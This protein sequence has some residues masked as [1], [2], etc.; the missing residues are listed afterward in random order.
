MRLLAAIDQPFTVSEARKTL[1]TTRRV[2][3]PL[4]ELL[5]A[6]GWTRRIDATRRIAVR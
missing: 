4:L 5:D 1:D 2:A 3:I 6:R